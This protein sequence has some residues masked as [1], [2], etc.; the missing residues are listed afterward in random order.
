MALSTIRDAINASS[1]LTTAGTITEY[2]PA[3][4]ELS[5]AFMEGLT[6]RIADHGSGIYQV[7][8]DGFYHFAP[9]SA[10]QVVNLLE[11]I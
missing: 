7:T 9:G 4:G 6:A 10:D 1:T 5:F 2:L 3:Y 11:G 8:L